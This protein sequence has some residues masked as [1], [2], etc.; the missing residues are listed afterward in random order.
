MSVD[1]T[2]ARN[3]WLTLP[4][5]ISVIRLLGVPVFL[6]LVLVL[7]ADLWAIVVLVVSGISDYLDGYLARRLNQTSKFG[8]LLDPIADRLY[9]L[10]TVIGLAA[11]GIIPIWFAVLLPLRD[12]LLWSLVPALRKR[13]YAALPVH[14]LG[15]TAT[16]ALLYAF[17]LFLLATVS[18]V[19]GQVA[20]VFAWA[21][22][23]WGAVLYWW[24]AV[25]YAIQ[26]RSL[27]R[28][29]DRG[30]LNAIEY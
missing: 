16:A 1:Q 12:V 2:V 22:A 5:A 6:W 10:S 15:K 14:F 30:V 28:L 27:V 23:L 13:G 3:S 19:V 4:N 8:Q 9:I 25:V 24:V 21:F 11:R 17:P 20:Q 18:S 7:H 29:H 26:V